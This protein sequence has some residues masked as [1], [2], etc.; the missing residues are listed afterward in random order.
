MWWIV[1]RNISIIPRIATIRRSCFWQNC[2]DD[3]IHRKYNSG[4]QHGVMLLGSVNQSWNNLRRERIK[5][6]L[7]RELQSICDTKNPV[8]NYLLGMTYQ[9]RWSM[10]RKQHGL[11]INLH[12]VIKCHAPQMC[13]STSHNINILH[14]LLTNN[15]FQPRVQSTIHVTEFTVIIETDTVWLDSSWQNGIFPTVNLQM[16]VKFWRLSQNC[17]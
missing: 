12:L 1:S 16:T 6:T 14:T 4:S 11:H 3:T 17:K 9:R 15:I 2:R 8:A 10:Y 5:A 7:S 13:S